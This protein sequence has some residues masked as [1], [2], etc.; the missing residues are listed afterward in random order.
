MTVTCFGASCEQWREIAISFKES[1]ILVTSSL[2]SKPLLAKAISLGSRRLKNHCWQSSACHWL[3]HPKQ[4]ERSWWLPVVSLLWTCWKYGMWMFILW[5]S[6]WSGYYRGFLCDVINVLCNAVGH[7]GVQVCIVSVQE[8]WLFVLCMG[9]E[10]VETK[11][12]SGLQI[13]ADIKHQCKWM[14]YDWPLVATRNGQ[15]SWELAK[16][17]SYKFVVIILLKVGHSMW[18]TLPRGLMTPWCHQPLP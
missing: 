1:S 6:S 10:E 13:S 14:L 16:A 8:W 17:T 12:L 4:K 2:M 18:T 3:C 5:S 11:T 7:V 15:E 9:A